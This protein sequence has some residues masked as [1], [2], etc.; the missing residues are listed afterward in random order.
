MNNFDLLD[1]IT[2]LEERFPNL[3]W[4]NLEDEDFRIYATI[5]W[6][7]ESINSLYIDVVE[8]EDEENKLIVTVE[9]SSEQNWGG[10]LK[11]WTGDTDYVIDCLNK[12]LKGLL[13]EINWVYTSE[14]ESTD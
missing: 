5:D 14:D 2:K 3:E 10:E 12:W 1:L 4:V 9:Y 13:T 6:E 8:S 7:D 11:R